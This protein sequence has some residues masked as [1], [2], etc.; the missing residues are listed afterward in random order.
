MDSFADRFHVDDMLGKAIGEANVEAQTA[1]SLRAQL[2]A[3]KAEKESYKIALSV[4][5]EKLNEYIDKTKDAEE[6]NRILLSRPVQSERNKALKARAEKAEADLASERI[7]RERAEKMW[8]TYQHEGQEHLER[9]ERAEAENK[10][11]QGLVDNIRIACSACGWEDRAEKAEIALQETRKALD[12]V[13]LLNGDGG[14]RMA[15][16]GIEQAVNEAVTRLD[17]LAQAEDE[18]ARM[19]QEICQAQEELEQAKELLKEILRLLRDVPCI[20]LGTIDADPKY[21]MGKR[22]ATFLNPEKPAK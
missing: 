16:V 10:R 5:S 20:E 13:A 4:T 15:E 22:L 14:H 6:E 19:R 18:N 21:N 1:E 12:L 7:Q 2:A 3:A 11:L 17:A 8:E 9:A